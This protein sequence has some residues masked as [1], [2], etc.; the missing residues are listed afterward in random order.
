MTFEERIASRYPELR[1]AEQRVVRFFRDRR[2]EV[3]IASAA[4]MAAKAKTSDATVIRAARALGY[5]GL[6]GLRRALAEEMRQSLSPAERMSRTLEEVGG[7]RAAAFHTT[8]GTHLKCLQAL[9]RSVIPAHFEKVAKALGGAKRVVAF[10]IGPSS[11][12]ANYL[13]IQLSRFGIEAISLSNT[14]LLFADDLAKLRANDVVILFAYS[15]IYVEVEALLDAAQAVRLR[16]IL[17]TDTL[18]GALK[19]RVDMIVSVPRGY[20]DMVSF[21]TTTLGFIEALLVGIA[22]MRP[23]PTLASLERLNLARRKLAG[24]KN[25]TAYGLLNRNRND[26]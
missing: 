7:E 19:G 22:A 9:S 16:T 24:K 26:R 11:A 4:T 14:G 15:R 17:V 23:E 12:M 2:E 13:V 8:I 5:S 18:E 1:P 3:L 6:D 25:A 20:S 21:H 10:G